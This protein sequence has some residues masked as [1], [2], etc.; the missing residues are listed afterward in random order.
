MVTFL[1]NVP[2]LPPAETEER[3]APDACDV[4]LSSEGTAL[5][6]GWCAVV[7]LLQSLS[8]SQSSF[9]FYPF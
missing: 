4:T 3:Q 2:V 8:L 9:F 1:I 7:L 5:P 6:P